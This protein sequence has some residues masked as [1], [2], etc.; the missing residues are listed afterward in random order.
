VDTE[1]T[2]PI[3][4]REQ[5]F[6]ETRDAELPN[7]VNEKWQR[8]DPCPRKAGEG[9]SQAALARG[10]FRGIAVADIDYYLSP[11]YRGITSRPRGEGIDRNRRINPMQ[12]R[13]PMHLSRR[14]GA[15]TRSGSGSGCRSPAMPNGRCRLHGG[16]SPGAPKG[17]KNAFKHG[18]YTA[19]AIGRRR[20]IS[21]LV[22]TM[23]ALTNSSE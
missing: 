16:M 23:K 9:A 17:N 8:P 20:E 10:D 11:D 3:H 21:G 7:Y 22:R 18:R 14:C 1:A 13:L 5:A 6:G 15:R 12:N 2:W 4:K 19:E